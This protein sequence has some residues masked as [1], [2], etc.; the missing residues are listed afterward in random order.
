V[1]IDMTG[2]DATHQEAVAQFFNLCGSPAMRAVFISGF[3][4]V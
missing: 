1:T 3:A 2:T 4:P